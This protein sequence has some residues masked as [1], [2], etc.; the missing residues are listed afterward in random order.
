M[1]FESLS[2]RVIFG[3]ILCTV[4]AFVHFI[5]ETHRIGR[6]QIRQLSQL[7]IFQS[8][9]K[10]IRAFLVNPNAWRYYTFAILFLIDGLFL[11]IFNVRSI[12]I[13]PYND[14][15]HD[16]SRQCCPIVGMFFVC[17]I[18]F[19]H[20]V[21]QYRQGKHESRGEAEFLTDLAILR[22]Q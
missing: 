21:S 12:T 8:L 17:K 4:L 19:A 1:K 3:T 10:L 13:T 11:V 9:V 6:I 15:C 2:K 14:V 20:V 7:L 18:M 22:I 16:N 5:R